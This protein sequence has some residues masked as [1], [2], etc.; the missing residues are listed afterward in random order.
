MNA[1]KKRLGRLNGLEADPPTSVFKGESQQ[2]DLLT[3][4]SLEHL[5]Y[6]YG[7]QFIDWHSVDGAV[8]D[9]PIVWYT[10][11][12]CVRKEIGSICVC[13]ISPNRIPAMPERVDS[14]RNVLAQLD[15]GDT[16]DNF[17]L[18]I[19]KAH[20]ACNFGT[21]ILARVLC[22]FVV[23][24]YNE[25]DKMATSPQALFNFMTDIPIGDGNSLDLIFG[26]KSTTTTY[27]KNHL[28]KNLK[29]DLN[30]MDSTKPGSYTKARPNC[31]FLKALEMGRRDLP[32]CTIL[33]LFRKTTKDQRSPDQLEIFDVFDVDNF[34]L[35]TLSGLLREDGFS[36]LR[37]AIDHACQ[38]GIMTQEL[39]SKILRFRLIYDKNRQVYHESLLT[40]DATTIELNSEA[41][42][43]LFLSAG[44]TSVGSGLA[45]IGPS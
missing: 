32:F 15:Y 28:T 7:R 43:R 26:N 2:E 22:A 42:H 21:V 25:G 27:V 31:P 33:N 23:T 16:K 8:N 20:H 9:P 5:K 37:N 11:S 39:F 38:H 40:V 45:R 10:S 36:R 41:N 12:A 24:R 34:E 13:S 3:M 14:I 4:F 17:W 44:F 35:V 29:K 6:C 30:Y 1:R 18:C 19:N